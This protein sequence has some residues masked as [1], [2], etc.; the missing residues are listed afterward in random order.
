[1]TEITREH[2]FNVYGTVSN[3]TGRNLE[4]VVIVMLTYLA[5]S[6]IIIRA[7]GWGVRV[8]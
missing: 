7:V 8:D 5:L 1:M 4:G 2:L 3:Q 6:W